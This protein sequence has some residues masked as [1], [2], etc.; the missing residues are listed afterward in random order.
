MR[1]VSLDGEPGRVA[2]TE[3]LPALPEV[4]LE[5]PPREDGALWSARLAPDAVAELDS[6]ALRWQLVLFDPAAREVRVLAG[7]A[8]AQRR[9]VFEDRASWGRDRARL[10]WSLEALL[11]HGC[12]ARTR[13]QR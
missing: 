11:E 7:R 8:E 12:V 6:G 10:E 5:E 1:R 4:A 2:A 9:L 3:I 13:G